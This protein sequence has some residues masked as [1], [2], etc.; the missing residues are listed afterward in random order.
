MTDF[1]AR[2]C[3]RLIEQ[4]RLDSLKRAGEKNQLGQFA[5]PP[6]L[7][8]EILRYARSLTGHVRFL[9][10]GLGTGSFYSAL[11]RVFE[12]ELIET[13]LGVELDPEF[14]KA[15]RRLW[16][17]TGLEVIEADFTAIEPQAR[18]NLVVSNPP[19]VRHHHLD[20]AAKERLQ[21]LVM[22]EHRIRISGLAGFY[23]HFLLL[24]NAWLEPGGL[25]IWL[26]PS[27]FMDVNYG[28]AVKRYLTDRVELVRIHRFNPADV[29]F[30]DALVSSAIV[31]FRKRCPPDDHQVC[32]SL[33]GS[34]LSPAQTAMIPVETLR[35]VR[36]WTAFPT[37]CAAGASV[38]SQVVLGDLF[39]IKRGIATGANNFF[40]L[41]EDQAAREGIPE[42]CRRPILPNP[43]YLANDVVE[44]DQRGYPVNTTRLALLD[45]HLPEETIEKRYPQFWQYLQRGKA[46]DIPGSYLASRRNP[47]YSQEKRD[48]APFL[49]T[50]M[51]RSGVG[52]K[53]FRVIWN[54]STAT[55]HNVYLLLYPSGPLKRALEDRPD[56]LEIVFRHLQSIELSDL[57]GE[58]RVYGGGLHKLEPNELARVP[59]TAL[60]QAIESI[61][62]YDLS[63]VKS[64]QL[65]LT[66]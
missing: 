58:G 4:Q 47:W 16:S 34:L 54:R 24:S 33:G 26:I 43:R 17:D 66:W 37:A 31:V 8:E 11:R 39:T 25:S 6:A 23:C 48:P 13:A 65:S 22:H 64:E 44:A 5:T 50:Y 51:G 52:R 12:K 28:H 19:Y 56:L 63:F 53:P 15:A 14:A 41:P 9:D 42:E 62:P 7:A 49:F 29:Q 40:I 3:D 38:G 35:E 2:E 55:A 10:P 59:A 30:T 61:H 1:A 32:M 36:K 57:L 18:F 20:A 45:C 46:R 21:R 60:W 27:E